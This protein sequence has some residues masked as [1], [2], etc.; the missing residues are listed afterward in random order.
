MECGGLTPLCLAL[1]G[2]R[3][4]RIL[5]AALMLAA[6]SASA[7]LAQCSMCRTGAEATGDGGATLN[8]AIMVL[9]FPVL[10]LFAG[11]LVPALLRRDR[12]PEPPAKSLPRTET[13]LNVKW[14]RSPR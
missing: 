12:E 6:L 7:A 9:V 8:L 3:T 11:I 5:C 14:L 10:T 2:I 13:V 1:M 4:I